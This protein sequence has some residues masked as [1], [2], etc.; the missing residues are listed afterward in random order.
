[1]ESNI[2]IKILVIDDEPDLE[3][4]IRQKFR[5]RLKAG[6]LEFVF[7]QDGAKGLNAIVSDSSIDLIMTDINMPVM[8]GLTLLSKLKEGQLWQKA[9][10][11]SAY[12]DIDNIR[13]AMNLGAFD[14]ITKPIDFSDLEIT[15]DKTI[16]ETIR[17]KEAKQTSEHLENLRKEKQQL[18]LEQNKTL[19]NK[20]R[21]RTEE[22]IKEKEKID[23]LLLN[24]LPK[25]VV[26]E[27]KESGK[28]LARLYENVTVIFADFVNFTKVSENLNPTELV[29]ILHHNYKTFDG[30]M[31][32]YG[33]EKI[34]TVGDAY[35]AV[36]GLPTT[37]EYHQIQAAKAA[38]EIRNFVSNEFSNGGSFQ[39]RIGMHS[40]PVVAGI[41][42]VKK[43]A[44]DIWGNTVNVASRMETLS[45]PGKIQVSESLYNELNS[46]F[47]FEERGKIEVKGKGQMSTYYLID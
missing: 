30:I 33:L 1:M 42:G 37:I 45:E 12:G 14:F 27:L 29:N 3:L 8:D 5:A 19:E 21:L 4:L 24:I 11:V 16:N 32:K 36:S 26:N 44:Y 6:E 18:I 9:I 10:I 2:P 15:L 13:T 47:N 39:I 41:V 7:A 43:F 31:E 20:V 35:I 46:K 23:D 28:S 40:G 17:L 22:L 25:E 38:I 34:K